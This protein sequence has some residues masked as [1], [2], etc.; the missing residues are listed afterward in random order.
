MAVDVDII[1][2]SGWVDA[3]AIGTVFVAEVR[4]DFGFVEDGVVVWLAEGAELI[5]GGG[6]NVFGAGGTVLGGEDDDVV[7]CGVDVAGGTKS[8]S[9]GGV[10]KKRLFGGDKGLKIV[11]V[12]FAGGYINGGIRRRRR[13]RGGGG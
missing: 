13:R 5:D 11:R 12:D 2:G 4:D 7:W 6:A 9:G 1:G 3:G 10:E 8:S